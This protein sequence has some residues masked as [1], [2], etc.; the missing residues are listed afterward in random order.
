MSVSCVCCTVPFYQ[1]VMVGKF[2]SMVLFVSCCI[3]N[4]LGQKYELIKTEDIPKLESC[5]FNPQTVKDVAC[6]ILAFLR[7]SATKEGHTYWLYKCQSL[8]H[9]L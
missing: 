3:F 8:L 6:N 9:S 1:T 7:N 5:K 2:S 4:L